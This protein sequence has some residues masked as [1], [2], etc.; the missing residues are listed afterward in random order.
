MP[1]DV[2]GRL[3]QHAHNLVGTHLKAEYEYFI[4]LWKTEIGHAAEAQAKAVSKQQAVLE[5][6]QKTTMHAL[7]KQEQMGLSMLAFVMLA[8]PAASWV[9]GTV[10][11]ILY[12]R[13]ASKVVTRQRDYWQGDK[14]HIETYLE[15]DHSKV[16]AKVFG[17]MSAGVAGFGVD[18]LLKPGAP[19]PGGD[20]RK[21]MEQVVSATDMSNFGLKLKDAVEA[22]AAVTKQA[23]LNLAM[24]IHKNDK[25]GNEC[26]QRLER[27]E[28][29]MKHAKPEERLARGKAMIEKD[30]DRHREK[31]ADEWFMYGREPLRAFEP[32]LIDAIEL[33]LWA[34]WIL[35]Q[36]FKVK[37]VRYRVGDVAG[38]TPQV[39]GRDGFNLTLGTPVL[40]R[41]A[42]FDVVVGRTE[43]QREQQLN[44]MVDG[45]PRNTPHINPLLEI[46]MMMTENEIKMLEEWALRYSV[47]R[48]GRGI[49][50]SMKRSV[51]SILN[52][53]KHKR[54][55]DV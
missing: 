48:G 40:E 41:L 51:G 14:Y 54:F 8:G 25:Y 34:L 53:H 26:L 20:V 7:Q 24:D 16:W 43:K 10:Q 52:A 49:L 38:S 46:N 5:A 35:Q 21:A 45:S 6:A 11:Y 2:E 12:P 1:I 28:P 37:M 39:I 27:L 36:E 17:D 13:L 18:K 31:W 30:I 47:W 22:N 42:E 19:K 29:R 32:R 4:T 23:I 50:D 33:E 15:K 9:A 55:Q 3:Q 44:R